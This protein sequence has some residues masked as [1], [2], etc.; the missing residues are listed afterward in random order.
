MTYFWQLNRTNVR[1]L[2]FSIAIGLANACATL[3]PA[4]RLGRHCAAAQVLMCEEFGPE[5]DCACVDD[6]AIAR[7]LGALGPPG[8]I[9]AAVW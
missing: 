9:G 8:A 4:P 7:F 2:F 1:I 3:E 6:R 5:R